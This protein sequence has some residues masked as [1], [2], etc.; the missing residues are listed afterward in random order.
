M[1]S[2]IYVIVIK[3]HSKNIF[4]KDGVCSLNGTAY[5]SEVVCSLNGTAKSNGVVCLLDGTCSRLVLN[6][7]ELGIQK[8]NLSNNYLKNT[9]LKILEIFLRFYYEK[10]Q[11]LWPFEPFGQKNLFYVKIWDRTFAFS[12]HVISYRFSLFINESAELQINIVQGISPI[13]PKVH[14]FH[15]RVIRES[16]SV[17]QT[18]C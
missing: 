10:N 6:N 12:A 14:D 4:F 13:F 2:Y 18:D 7:H 17:L 16:K 15:F 1:F 9:I 8:K 5:F 11:I 3:E